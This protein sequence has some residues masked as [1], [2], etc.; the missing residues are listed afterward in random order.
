MTVKIVTQIKVCSKCKTGKSISEFYKNNSRCDGLQTRCKVC[1]HSERK[2]YTAENKEK[3]LAK[4]AAWRAENREKC[5]V[6]AAAW[7][8]AHPDK[9]KA[10]S[11]AWRAKNP[12]KVKADCAAWSAENKDR[13][14]SIGAAWKSANPDK[15]RIYHQNRRARSSGGKLSQGLAEQLYKLQRGKCPCCGLPLGDKYHMDHIVPLALGGSNTDDNIQLLKSKCN[16]NKSAKHP[17][18]FMQSKGFLL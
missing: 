3:L 12:E 10:C 15:V 1:A 2:K 6:K 5:R 4:Q 18:D 13:V 8:A 16:L 9:A 11:E 7:Y 17:I 14:A